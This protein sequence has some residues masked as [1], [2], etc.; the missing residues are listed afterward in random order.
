M[1]RIL[2]AG[3]WL[4]VLAASTSISAHE[5]RPGYLEIRQIEL[6][7]FDVYMQFKGYLFQDGYRWV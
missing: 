1:K 7:A 6:G 3:I 4:L 5:I 2:V